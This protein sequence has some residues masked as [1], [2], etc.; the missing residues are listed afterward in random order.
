MFH[1]HSYWEYIQWAKILQNFLKLHCAVNWS[2]IL[3]NHNV[4]NIFFLH[5][6]YLYIFT[7]IY[8]Y[9]FTGHCKAVCSLLA[10]KCSVLE[11]LTE[12]VHSDV[13]WNQMS[14][15]KNSLTESYYFK[16]LWMCC[17]MPDTLF[18]H[19]FDKI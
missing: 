3:C 19:S 16:W 11:K 2:K 14:A 18:Y 15:S 13:K 5:D 9:I 10:M 17:L 12:S 1:I 4:A 7:S 8:A 6:I